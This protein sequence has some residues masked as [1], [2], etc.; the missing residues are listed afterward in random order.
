[1]P[2]FVDRLQN[3]KKELEKIRIKSQNIQGQDLTEYASDAIDIKIFIRN[4]PKPKQEQKE[5]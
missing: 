1:M 3:I 5:S 2:E 4:A